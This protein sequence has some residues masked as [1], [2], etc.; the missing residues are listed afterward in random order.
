MNDKLE[1]TILNISKR[2]GDTILMEQRQTARLDKIT[3]MFDEM[4]ITEKDEKE[5]AQ[6]MASVKYQAEDSFAKFDQARASAKTDMKANA[7]AKRSELQMLRDQLEQTEQDN[8]DYK[9]RIQQS[10]RADIEEGN[11]G[12]TKCSQA[13]RLLITVDA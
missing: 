10:R 2:Q 8:Q 1:T 6:C 13:Y 9:A 4:H 7:N 11:D 12:N 3:F 5:K